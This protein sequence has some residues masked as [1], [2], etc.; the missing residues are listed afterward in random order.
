MN[1]VNVTW[2]NVFEFVDKLA[3]KY[4]DKN[5]DCILAVARGGVFI[6]T[7]LSYKLDIPV[8]YVGVSSYIGNKKMDNVHF[9]QHAEISEF[10]NILVIDDIID[11]GDT[12]QFVK[13]VLGNSF[14]KHF[15]F[16]TMFAVEGKENDIDWYDMIKRKDEWVE[17]PWELI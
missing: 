5:F 6:G 4:K 16:V 15:E 2:E 1:K 10:K 12:I 13:D 17:F 11:S 3:K 8:R 14:D 9:T 7:L